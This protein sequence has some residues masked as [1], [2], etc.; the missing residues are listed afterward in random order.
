MR[1]GYYLKEAFSFDFQWNETHFT[2][3]RLV[4]KITVYVVQNSSLKLMQ[5]SLKKVWILNA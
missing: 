3:V 5:N 2:G 4:D 1:Q